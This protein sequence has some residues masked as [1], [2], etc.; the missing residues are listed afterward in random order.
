M[1]PYSFPQ[2]EG[3]DVLAADDVETRAQAILA[4]AAEEGAR[5]RADAVA[6]GH[7][8]GV[9]QGLRDIHDELGLGKEA[10]GA[11]VNS[12]ESY[13]SEFLGRIEAEA[14]E[15]ALTLAERIV[16]IVIE[17]DREA[18]VRIVETAL[19]ATGACEKVVLD[20]NPADWPI[21]NEALE[22]MSARI[23]DWRS[24]ELRRSP[25]VAPGGCVVHT[26]QGEIDA[27]PEQ[28]VAVAANILRG[29]VEKAL[30]DA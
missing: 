15:L 24:L 17:I 18:V 26:E 27:S 29:L 4:Q 11:V 3:F 22:S 14:V 16:N 20:V 6:L 7:A 12:V 2:L 5:M 21:V 25:T 23:S 1:E 30:R 8:E 9:A 19:R 10:I 13:E 28:Q